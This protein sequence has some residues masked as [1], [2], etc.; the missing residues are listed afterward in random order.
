MNP[1][2]RLI[3]APGPTEGIC[4]FSLTLQL[5]PGTCERSVQTG[6]LESGVEMKD[7]RSEY[8]CLKMNLITN[9]DTEFNL[10]L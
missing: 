1:K 5:L 9:D 10:E 8:H 7:V 2:K 4:R 3:Q 6:K